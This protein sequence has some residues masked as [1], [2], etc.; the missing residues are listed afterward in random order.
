[1]DEDTDESLAEQYVYYSNASNATRCVCTKIALLQVIPGVGNFLDL[2]S[3][4]LT[5]R[6]EGPT[7]AK[8]VHC[9]CG[10]RPPKEIEL[11]ATH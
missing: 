8:G 2:V 1:M 4:R 9:T 7:W 5:T 10:A 11:P 6:T 3:V